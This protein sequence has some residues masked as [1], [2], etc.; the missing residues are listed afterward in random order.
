MLGSEKSSGLQSGFNQAVRTDQ[1]KVRSHHRAIHAGPRHR[2]DLF[3]QRQRNDEVAA[4]LGRLL[5]RRSSEFRCEGPGQMY[6]LS[7]RETSQTETGRSHAWIVKF[8]AVVNQ[9]YSYSANWD[10]AL[11]F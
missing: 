8:A 6:G 11:S 7:N 10:L 4:A 3:R 5:E 2:Y 9:Y 1:P